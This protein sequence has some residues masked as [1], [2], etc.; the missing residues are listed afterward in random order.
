MTLSVSYIA[1]Q[2]HHNFVFNQN[3]ILEDIREFGVRTKIIREVFDNF[4]VIV[5]F[6][7]FFTERKG[8]WENYRSC[9]VGIEK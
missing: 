6:P 9:F 2:F 5:G 4:A 8:K 1:A 7:L 3:R